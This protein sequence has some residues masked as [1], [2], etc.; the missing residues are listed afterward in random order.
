MIQEVCGHSILAEQ[1][2]GVGPLFKVNSTD[3]MTRQVYNP[4]KLSFHVHTF[5]QSI[6]IESDW[7]NLYG[8]EA[9]KDQR[10][11]KLHKLMADF[12][13]AIAEIKELLKNKQ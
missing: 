10:K 8:P 13:N 11:E 7:F 3:T 12:E 5:Q 4:I 1:I 6:L 9:E 2:I